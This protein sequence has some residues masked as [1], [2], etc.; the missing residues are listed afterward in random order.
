MA[1]SLPS[2]ASVL[3][4]QQ[5]SALSRPLILHRSGQCGGLVHIWEGLNFSFPL[6]ISS[7]GKPVSILLTCVSHLKFPLY[8]RDLWKAELTMTS[9]WIY[10]TL[11]CKG[12]NGDGGRHVLLNEVWFCWHPSIQVLSEPSEFDLRS[13]SIYLLLSFLLISFT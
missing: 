11:H 12:F 9:S 8:L 10:C 13:R 5:P 4:R 3:S 2:S 6:F 7:T 1:L